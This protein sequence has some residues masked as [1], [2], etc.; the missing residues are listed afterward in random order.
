[1]TV[2]QLHSQCPNGSAVWDL[3]H[4]Y[5]QGIS[6]WAMGAFKGILKGFVDPFTNQT[7]GD[8]IIEAIC[9]KGTH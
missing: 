1:M 4:S 9:G 8:E 3:A 6:S 5:L 7:I 2:Q